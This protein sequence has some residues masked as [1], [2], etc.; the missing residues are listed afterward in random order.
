MKIF[1]IVLELIAVALLVLIVAALLLTTEAMA[2]NVLNK[3]YVSIDKEVGIGAADLKCLTDNV[4]FEARNEPIS[5]QIAVVLVTLNRVSDKRWPK[6]IC[7]V[8]WQKS[9]FSWTIDGKSDKPRN[10]RTWLVIYNLV[11]KV[12]YNNMDNKLPTE[13][14]KFNATHYHANYVN[15]KWN[16]NL[17]KVKVVGA[18]I[19]YE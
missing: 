4:Y 6:S 2:N 5:G 18:H 13:Y 17:K 7:S 11:N 10:K 15:P 14:K 3:N 12:Y 8:V 19:F 16:K 9:Q 1:Y